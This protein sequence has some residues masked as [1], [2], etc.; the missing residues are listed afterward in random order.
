[1]NQL[2]E[3]WETGKAPVMSSATVLVT[4]APLNPIEGTIAL[5][6]YLLALRELNTVH[7]T[8]ATPPNFVY[9]GPRQH[10]N[11][12]VEIS[13]SAGQGSVSCVAK[14]N[15]H[16]AEKLNLP[17]FGTEETGKEAI[18][19]GQSKNGSPKFR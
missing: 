14:I 7:L 15:D 19:D 12:A 10:K 2:A 8:F 18:G 13:C 5:E 3:E 17:R 11:E 16:T 1:M 6:E 4:G 9:R